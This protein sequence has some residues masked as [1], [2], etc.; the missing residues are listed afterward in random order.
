MKYYYQPTTPVSI[1]QK[2]NIHI[3]TG[4]EE[5]FLQSFINNFNSFNFSSGIIDIR[6]H[7]SLSFGMTESSGD[8]SDSSVH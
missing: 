2:V 4:N 6:F 7:F 8:Y 1:K 3:L 5:T